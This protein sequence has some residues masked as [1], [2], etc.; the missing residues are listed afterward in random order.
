M[1]ITSAFAF[2]Y[3]RSYCGNG[4]EAT[5]LSPY[6]RSESRSPALDLKMRPAMMLAGRRLVEIKALIYRGIKSDGTH[7][8]AT[9]YLLLTTDKTRDSR[10]LTDPIVHR[11]GFVRLRV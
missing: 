2:G 8:R 10:L 5:R 1:S 3:V 6:F 7:P 9:A 11:M 4:C